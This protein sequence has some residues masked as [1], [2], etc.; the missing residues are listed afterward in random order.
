MSTSPLVKKLLI[1]PGQR[2][3]VLNAPRGYLDR[4]A[5]LPLDV[6]CVETPDGTLRDVV[7]LFVRDRAELE[8]LGPAALTAAKR[9]GVLWISYP[10]RS[11][12]VAT[13]LTRDIGWELTTGAGFEGVAQVAIDETWSA[14]RFRP[15]ELVKSRRKQ[16]G[17]RKSTLP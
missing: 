5:P 1:K 4:L 11:S 17:R 8:R 7:H 2:I 6:D 13:D 15:A 9:N 3:A 14:T 12:R 10:K 16:V